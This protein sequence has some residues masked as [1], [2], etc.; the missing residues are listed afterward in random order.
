V[1]HGTSQHFQ[2][3]NLNKTKLQCYLRNLAK[4]KNPCLSQGSRFLV[5]GSLKKHLP[6][7]IRQPMTSE[8]I[9]QRI[10]SIQTKL[11][12]QNNSQVTRQAQPQA[13]PNV[14]T[15]RR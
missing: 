7:N 9:D 6:K 11:T 8:V 10:S 15:C 4:D 1:A 3:K 5:T 2:S 13:V 12:W 14:K